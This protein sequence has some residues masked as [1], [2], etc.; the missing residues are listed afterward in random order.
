MGILFQTVGKWNNN[1]LNSALSK[2]R[3]VAKMF[4]IGGEGVDFICFI[5]LFDMVG[6]C[7]GKNNHVLEKAICYHLRNFSVNNDFSKSHPNKVK[8]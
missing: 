3:D 7:T 5:F 1:L 4:H 8:Q 6:T 2:S